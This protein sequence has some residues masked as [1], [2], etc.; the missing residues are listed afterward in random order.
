MKLT[1]ALAAVN[2]PDPTKIY[3]N[4]TPPVEFLAAGIDVR[5]P[6][7]KGAWMTMTGNSF[8]AP[9]VAAVCALIRAR[10]PDLDTVGVK[11][12]LR[13]LAEPRVKRNPAVGYA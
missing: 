5:V 7:P 8:A 12:V 13:D 9:R 11:A 10:H 3:Y 1:S 4:L 6:Q 2:E